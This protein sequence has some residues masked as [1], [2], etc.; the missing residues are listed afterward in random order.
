MNVFSYADYRTLL[1]EYFQARKSEPAG[2]TWREFAK[3]CGYASPVYLKLVIENKTNLSEIGVERVASAIG[4][5]G[6]E[7]QYFRALVRFNQA[8]DSQTK[9]H[10]YQEMREVSE[11]AEVK[12]LQADQYDYY[13]SWVHPVLRELAPTMPAASAKELGECLMPAVSAQQVRQ[14]LELLQR[15]GLLEK[16]NDKLVQ[17]TQS[18]STGSEVTSLAVRDLH[19]QMAALAMDS[20]EN[21]PREERDISGLTLGVSTDAFERIVRELAEFRRR[22]VAIATEDSRTDRVVRLN[23]QLFPLSRQVPNQGEQA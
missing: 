9:K 11:R 15:V 14:S 23:L 22:V 17:T 1:L 5:A 12:V 4:F 19:R 7:L 13:Q 20:L 10:A 8:K 3:V 6:R 18:I 2:F 21:I 16:Q